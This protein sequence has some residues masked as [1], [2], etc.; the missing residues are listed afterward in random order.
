MSAGLPSAEALE[1]ALRGDGA[2]AWRLARGAAA[3]DG[4]ADASDAADDVLAEL[5]AR[6]DLTL[7]ALEAATGGLD[8]TQRP[9]LR[10]AF[11]RLR[12]GLDLEG[13]LE[14]LARD[15]SLEPR[16]LLGLGVI[17]RRA[18]GWFA[19][20]ARADL[21]ATL[22]DEDEPDRLKVTLDVLEAEVPALARLEAAFLST[23]R[24]Q[25][26]AWSWRH[27]GALVGLAVV[28]WRWA[29]YVRLGLEGA[30]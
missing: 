9:D 12:A 30:P 13:V 3:P 8:L 17:L 24:A 4:E 22:R 20:E 5:L 1:A 26:R 29:L 19:P 10:R 2:R 16:L 14:A 21:L 6:D 25:A 27:Q 28:I 11:E 23:L 7:A 15:P 18:P